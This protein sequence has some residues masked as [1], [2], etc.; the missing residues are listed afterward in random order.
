MAMTNEQ[1]K[2]IVEGAVASALAL[3]E[4]SFEQKLLDVQKRLGGVNISTLEVETYM[5]ADIRI[6]FSC[7]ET[8]DIMKSLPDFEGKNK[9]YV[10]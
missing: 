2:A 6:S 7:S 8:L 5:D 1:L 3:Q 10:S 4:R 9:T